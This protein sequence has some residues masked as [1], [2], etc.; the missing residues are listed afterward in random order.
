VTEVF[1]PFDKKITLDM[2]E[3]TLYSW[4]SEEYEPIALQVKDR[5]NMQ[6]VRVAAEA[7][8]KGDY[9]IAPLGSKPN[10][11]VTFYQKGKGI[12][13]EACQPRVQ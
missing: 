8:A 4:D 5:R 10:D 12:K 6:L 2:L 3:K 11:K 1:V 13:V 7:I 9:I